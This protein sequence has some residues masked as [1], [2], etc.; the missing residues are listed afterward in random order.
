MSG[1]QLNSKQPIYLLKRAREILYS[2]SQSQSSFVFRYADFVRFVRD[3]KKKNII[4]QLQ[5]TIEL[6]KVI[7][8]ITHRSTMTCEGVAE[9]R[10]PSITSKRSNSIKFSNLFI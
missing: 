3:L 6:E 9:V 7:A 2:P 8:D 1:N 4:V 5:L 10:R